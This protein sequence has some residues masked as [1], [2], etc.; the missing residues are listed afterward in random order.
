MIATLLKTLEHSFQCP[1]NDSIV[2]EI[3]VRDPKMIKTIKIYSKQ[4]S[5]PLL[6]CTQPKIEHPVVVNNKNKLR[7]VQ[8]TK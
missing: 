5:K 1:K 7:L 2:I 8:N 3:S 4:Q 6:A